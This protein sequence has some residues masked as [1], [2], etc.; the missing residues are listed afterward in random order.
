[1]NAPDLSKL[2]VTQRKDREREREREHSSRRENY[3]S[4]ET[5]SE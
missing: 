1:M 5:I 3:L 2:V 4:N